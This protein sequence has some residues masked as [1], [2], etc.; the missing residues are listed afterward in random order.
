[1]NYGAQTL[2][3]ITAIIYNQFTSLKTKHANLD[4]CFILKFLIL[5]LTTAWL[6]PFSIYLILTLVRNYG[7]NINKFNIDS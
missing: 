1:M 2:G 6:I 5:Y 4:I 7:F 3:S